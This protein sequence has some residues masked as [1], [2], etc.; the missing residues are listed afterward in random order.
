MVRC[1]VSIH[2]PGRGTLRVTQS[3]ACSRNARDVPQDD[4]G[5]VPRSQRLSIG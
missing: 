4:P 5:R 1:R 3:S 2:N